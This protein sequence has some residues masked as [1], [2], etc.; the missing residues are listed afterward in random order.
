MQVRVTHGNETGVCDGLI[1]NLLRSIPKDCV[2]GVDED[3]NRDTRVEKFD[4]A[5]R[6]GLADHCG[7]RLLQRR[8]A[9]K[10]ALRPREHGVL[11]SPQNHEIHG[12]HDDEDLKF[13]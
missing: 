4:E 6:N 8:R 2:V 10:G 7:E 13:R 1:H 11:P 12:R 3:T 9:L 5:D